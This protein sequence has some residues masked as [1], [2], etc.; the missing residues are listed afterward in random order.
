[1]SG[2]RALWYL[3]TRIRGIYRVTDVETYHGVMEK[4]DRSDVETKDISIGESVGFM[5]GRSTTEATYLLW[6]MME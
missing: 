6:M 2:E 5:L 4:G 3:S 1:M